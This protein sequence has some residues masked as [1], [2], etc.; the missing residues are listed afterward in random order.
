MLPNREYINHSQSAFYTYKLLQPKFDFKWHYHPEIEINLIVRG[1]GKRL[2]GDSVQEF[3][4]GEITVFGSNL[5]HTYVSS[6]SEEDILSYGV[7]FSSEIIGPKLLHLQEFSAISKLLDRSHRGLMI[8]TSTFH[9]LVEIAEE[10][11]AT[12]GIHRYNLLLKLLDKIG[13]KRNYQLLASEQY[14]IPL[15]KH[16]T[17]RF[18]KT[19]RYI[20]D[21]YHRRISIDEMAQLTNLSPTSFCRYF[22]KQTGKTFIEYV[23]TWKV[24]RACHLLIHSD[25]PIS[26]IAFETGFNNIVHFNRT[27][28]FSKEMT[29]SAYRRHYMAEA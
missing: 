25:A 13:K 3:T 5:P 23:N 14:E 10:M 2:V 9:K 24:Q 7:Q 8:R 16:V 22:K 21:N 11:T 15:N 29:P 4:E 1:Q 18:D 27:F 17:F 6:P 19:C 12:S 20:H 26:Q 28:H